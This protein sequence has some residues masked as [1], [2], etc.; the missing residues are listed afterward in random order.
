LVGLGTVFNAVR[1]GVW[2]DPLMVWVY[3]LVIPCAVLLIVSVVMFA[4]TVR[5]LTE[6]DCIPGAHPVIQLEV[7]KRVQP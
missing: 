6:K 3:V 4:L 5:P 2:R 7:C 1:R